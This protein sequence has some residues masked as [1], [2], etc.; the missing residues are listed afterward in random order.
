MCFRLISKEKA[1]NRPKYW[2]ILPINWKRIVFPLPAPPL[3]CCVSLTR[4]AIDG[5]QAEAGTEEF[6]SH[7]RLGTAVFFEPAPVAYRTAGHSTPPT[8]LRVEFEQ[9]KQQ[10]EAAEVPKL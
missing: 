7:P 5:L 10:T 2:P 6:W 3:L 8:A 1:P 9:R 4:T